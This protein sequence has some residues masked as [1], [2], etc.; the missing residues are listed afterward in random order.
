MDIEKFARGLYGTD[1]Q[2]FKELEQFHERHK[3][4]HA[5]TYDNET[6]MPTEAVYRFVPYTGFIDHLRLRKAL[7]ELPPTSEGDK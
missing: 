4:A 7:A 1:E 6:R 5:I 3:D 2:Y